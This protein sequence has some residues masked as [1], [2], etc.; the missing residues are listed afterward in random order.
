MA[1]YTGNFYR[2]KP[3]SLSRCSNSRCAYDKE[4][5]KIW[6]RLDKIYDNQ[7]DISMSIWNEDKSKCFDSGD[8]DLR[9]VD[10]IDEPIGSLTKTTFMQI[11]STMMK[12]LLDADLQTLAKVGYL[13]GN[14]E[15]TE[16]GKKA[17]LTILFLAN[18]KDLVALATEEIAEAEKAAAKK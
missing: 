16:A 7:V 6:I 14:L 8:D 5:G 2:I 13:D 10:L 15:L 9:T 12:K 11:L 3:A 4:K 18:K 17:L 1:F